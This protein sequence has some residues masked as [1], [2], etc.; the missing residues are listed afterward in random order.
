MRTFWIL[1]AVSVIAALV[2]VG[3]NQEPAAT[4]NSAPDHAS[5]ASVTRPPSADVRG[6]VDFNDGRPS[7]SGGGGT[8]DNNIFLSQ[9][10]YNT[11]YVTAGVGGLRGQ[12]S[13]NITLAGLVGSPTLALLY[14]SG[15]T[16]STDPTEDAHVTVNGTAIVGTNIGF[17]SD[18]CWGFQNSQAYVADVTTIVAA[19]GNGVYALTGLGTPNADNNGASLLVFFHDADNTN[20]RDIVIFH[21]NDSNFPNGYDADGWNVTLA[22]INYTTGTA[23]MQLHV[24]DGQTY[25]DDALTLN[26]DPN[27]VPGPQVFDGNTVPSDNNGPLDNGNLWDIRTF[28][29]T[30]YLSPGPNTLTLTTGQVNDCLGL[31]VAVINL[32]AGAAPNQAVQ[33]DMHPNSCPN[34]FNPRSQGVTPAAI[35]GTPGLD[36]TTIDISTIRLLGVA[37]QSWGFEDVATPDAPNAP[38]CQ[39][40]SD[41]PDGTTDL[42]LKFNTQA[43]AAALG[44]VNFGDVITVTVTFSLRNGTQLSG[45]DCIVIRGPHRSQS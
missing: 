3:C 34:P 9:T 22:G 10:I 45:Q 12:T 2:Y 40:N 35:L 26:G 42:V 24:T 11:D 4:Q 41:G 1:M 6:S 38:V 20:N 19:T 15:P 37:P 18:N 8:L 7:R 23:S 17:S 16:N 21:G 5:I 39:C 36:V 29:V 13:G 31:I 33:F 25:A 14:W 27:F 44:P 30:S 28:D 43:L 32:P